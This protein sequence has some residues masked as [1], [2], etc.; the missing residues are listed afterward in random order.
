MRFRELD[1]AGAFLIQADVMEDERGAFARTYCRREFAAHGLAFDWV[2]CNTSLTLR[3]G[4]VRG[5]HYQAAPHEEAKLIRCTA[6]AIYD[7]A[8]DIRADSPTFRRWVS[9]EL[10]AATPDM[11]YLPEGVAHGFQ[12]LT[13][14]AEVFYQM[15][16]FYEHGAVRGV[17]WNDPAFRVAWPEEVT[18]ISQRDA[19]YPDFRL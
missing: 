12:T 10:S 6:G 11:V 16:A 18:L 9:V 5:L 1:I 19:S 3:R 14:R 4:S 15:S 2:Q 13:D 17:R 8:V 7:V